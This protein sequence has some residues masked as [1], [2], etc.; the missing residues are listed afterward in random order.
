MKTLQQCTESKLSFSQFLN[1][2]DKV[3][4]SIVDYFIEVLPPVTMNNKCVQMGEPYNHNSE[5]KPQFLTLEKITGNWTYA[6]IK[7]KIR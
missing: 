5:G 1:I 2:G 7:P 4:E 3:D 6:G